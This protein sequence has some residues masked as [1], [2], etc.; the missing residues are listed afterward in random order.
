MKGIYWLQRRLVLFLPKGRSPFAWRMM[1]HK[2]CDRQWQWLVQY[3][4]LTIVT[5]GLVVAS[6]FR[7]SADP[8]LPTLPP[9]QVHPL[10]QTLANW[11]NRDRLGDYFDQ[12]Q[13]LPIGALVWSRFPVKVY[14]ESAEDPAPTKGAKKLD[15]QAQA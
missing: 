14:V 5:V 11:R 4:A 9:S 10:P 13:P 8:P 2:G 1:G 15:P 12:I 7:V 3:L 6:G